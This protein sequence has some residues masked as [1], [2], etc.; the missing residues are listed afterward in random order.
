MK[1][2]QSGRWTKQLRWFVRLRWR[3]RRRS[4]ERVVYSEC[5]CYLLE[6]MNV[7]MYIVIR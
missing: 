6:L 5:G 7:S 4:V 1:F 3:E 2:L